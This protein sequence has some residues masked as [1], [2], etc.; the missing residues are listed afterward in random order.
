VWRL[1]SLGLAFVAVGYAG[2]VLIVHWSEFTQATE[3]ISIGACGIALTM[4][5]GATTLFALGWIKLLRSFHYKEAATHGL[6]WVFAQSWIA[7]YVPGKVAAP[8]S[9][10]N[11]GQKLGYPVPL[12]VRSLGYETTLQITTTGIVGSLLILLS[13]RWPDDLTVVLSVGV[14]GALILGG[15]FIISWRTDSSARE[16]QKPRV[17][18]G[19]VLVVIGLSIGAALLGGL[20]VATLVPGISGLAGLL[21]I[22]GAANFAGTLS[23]VAILSPA[24]LGVRE[25]ILTALLAPMIGAPAGL[26]VAVLSRVLRIVADLFFGGIC[27]LLDRPRSS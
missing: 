13:G 22:M 1:A 19:T 5:V 14:L 27:F 15:V 4:F 16:E 8:V 10:V 26:S 24:G 25:G 3:E 2:R 17:S 6:W 20:G 18:Q 23:T 7:R 9:R 12:L 11:G 21:Y